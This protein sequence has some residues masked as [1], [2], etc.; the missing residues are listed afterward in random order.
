MASFNQR[1]SQAESRAQ[2]V[3][4]GNYPQ[5]PENLNRLVCSVCDL[6]PEVRRRAEQDKK[7]WKLYLS[8]MRITSGMHNTRC[9]VPQCPGTLH[10]FM[11]DSSMVNRL[12][13][14]ETWEIFSNVGKREIS[15]GRREAVLTLIGEF[16]YR[17]HGGLTHWRKVEAFLAQE[18]VAWAAHA[19]AQ[20]AAI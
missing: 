8:I 4:G 11:C 13:Y 20:E 1:L 10:C 5:C 12:L 9:M 15:P 17:Q 3:R 6:E 19:Q 7:T 18:A 14:E 16:L 2:R